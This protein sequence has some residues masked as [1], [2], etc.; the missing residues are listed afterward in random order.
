MNSQPRLIVLLS[1]YNGEEF[2]REQ[3]DSL[4]NQ[5]YPD[6]LILARD[7][8]S[9]DA[10]PGIL[11]DYAIRY[12]EQLQVLDL[13]SANRGA[14]ASFA[15]LMA[16]ALEHKADLGVDKPY[17]LF[18]DQDDVW[19]RDKMAKQ[20]NAMLAT[21][22]SSADDEIL[23]TLVHTDLRVV[24]EKLEPIAESLARFQGLQIERNTFPNL[25]VSNL[26]TGCTALINE[27]LARKALPIP[28]DAIMHDWWLALVASAFGQIVY[29]DAPLIQYRQHGSNTIGAQAL[30]GKRKRML[31][32]SK[33]LIKA[34]TN[35]HLT[36][37]AHQASAFRQQYEVS[38]SKRQSRAL[39]YCSALTTKIGLL[40][41]LYFRLI[42]RL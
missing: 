17:L 39:R 18:C 11:A 20:V 42:R 36:A 34:G 16:Y 1:T 37:V 3:L 15:W 33:K 41:S 10:T 25:L 24:D 40:Q 28:E 35:K 5:T 32:F 2:V 12:P 21:E 19:H 6:F 31:A 30:P 22:A 4:F 23:P 14:A 9:D 26:V 29:L 8:G 27:S 38:L 13:G 7:D